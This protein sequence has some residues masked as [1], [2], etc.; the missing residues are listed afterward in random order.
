MR[1]I[2][3]YE[4]PGCQTNA[5]QRKILGDAGHVV[6]AKSILKEPWT[7]DALHRFLVGKSVA[8]WFNPA[9]PAIKSGQVDP[10]TLDA[11]IALEMLV[12]EP[13]LIKRPL[14]EID[15][16]RA[17]GFDLA[18]IEGCVGGSL[19][20]RRVAAAQGCSRPLEAIP[21]PDPAGQPGQGG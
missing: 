15:G 19:D 7:Q 14:I 12:A 18:W 3:F 10:R 6:V 21:C 5:R 9:A 13:I 8:E 17:A 16:Q 20:P 11:S 1:T 4:K 2:I